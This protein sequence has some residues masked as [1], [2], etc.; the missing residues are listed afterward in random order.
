MFSMPR[1][2][3]SVACILL[4]AM[5]CQDDAHIGKSTVALS[6]QTTTLS[7]EL[8][9]A[10]EHA[11]K[12][13]VIVNLR[14][15]YSIGRA[16]RAQA[17]ASRVN[18]LR[19]Q[20]GRELVHAR[21]YQHTPAFA[22]TLTRAGLL[23]LEDHPDVAS[24]Q[25][26]HRGR[27]QLTEA[28]TAVQASAVHSVLQLTGRGVRVAVL[29]TGVQADHP[30]LSDAVVAQR[31]FTRG[32]CPPLRRNEGEDASDDNGHGTSVAGAIASRGR[33]SGA[34]FAPGAELVVFKVL[35]ADTTGVESD[36]VAALDYIYANLD[37]LQVKLV[38]LSFVSEQLFDDGTCDR[39]APALAGAIANLTRSGVAVIG[40]SGNNGS[41]E[42]L[43]VPACNSG[44]IG[45]GASYDGDVGPMPAGAGTFKQLIGGAFAACRDELSSATRLTCY[46]NSSPRLDLI[47][48]G[49]PIISDWIGGG[50]SL[51]GG[52]SYAAAAV[53]GIGA[54]LWECNAELDPSA[55]LSVLEATGVPLLD[56]RNGLSFPLVQAEGAVRQACPGLVLDAGMAAPDAGSAA[57]ADAGVPRRQDAGMVDAGVSQQPLAAGSLSTGSSTMGVTAAPTVPDAATSED[58]DPI[59]RIDSKLPKGTS[60]RKPARAPGPSGICASVAPGQRQSR[61][62]SAYLAWAGLLAC[63]WL[64][65][66]K[67]APMKC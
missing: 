5:S 57:A 9:A 50:T 12:L 40:A 54:L 35:G 19:S 1:L 20:L 38:N 26:D 46:T 7:L 59:A 27:A 34:G 24:V 51:R 14:E 23:R 31:C 18:S 36:W 47:A 44:V 65:R 55:L 25:L 63:S 4:L 16:Q 48:P 45:V 21:S 62:A 2:G 56:E 41:S 11:P 67:R 58:N 60:K 49:S 64:R 53:T 30:D 10:M 8:Q 33:L 66:R 28:V 3:Y 29:D 6:K 32:A 52:T 43:A 37:R 39:A 13:D 17:I 22:G 61:D 15:P 42:Q